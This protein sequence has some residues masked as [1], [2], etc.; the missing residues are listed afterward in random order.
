MPIPDEAFYLSYSLDTFLP[1]VIP[2]F[3]IGPKILRPTNSQ[4]LTVA[5]FTLNVA[6]KKIGHHTT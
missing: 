6:S 1:I 4:H 2:K 3:R 5:A